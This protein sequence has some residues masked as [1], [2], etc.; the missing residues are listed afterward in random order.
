MGDRAPAAPVAALEGAIPGLRGG[1]GAGRVDMLPWAT[2][3]AVCSCRS[4]ARPQ[5][6]WGASLLHCTETVLQLRGHTRSA[7]PWPRKGRPSG[8]Q[9]SWQVG[10]QIGR[11]GS[12]QQRPSPHR[13]GAGTQRGQRLVGASSAT[14][15]QSRASDMDSLSRLR[16]P[17][18]SLGAAGV[19]VPVS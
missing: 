8:P 16:H 17:S 6:P 4:L 13:R 2:F 5:G 1:K 7:V 3:Q 10:P 11:L 12:F 19:R 14:S 18:L 9:L 15:Q